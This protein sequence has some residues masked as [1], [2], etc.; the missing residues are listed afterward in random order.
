M[1]ANDTTFGQDAN[2]YRAA[3]PTYPDALFDWI[4][5]E[6]P[7]RSLVWDV[8]TGSGQAAVALAARFASVHAT[9]VD[10]RQV[11]AAAPHPRVRYAAAPAERSGLAD[12]SADAVTV[13]TALHWFD[14]A[15]FWA[16][17]RR[18]LRPGGVFCAWTY[19]RAEADAETEARLLAPILATIDPYW[20][21]GN[22]LSW[23][24]Y[25]PDEIA[26]PFA[27]LTPPPFAC[28][29]R[30]SPAE[31]AGFVRSWSAYRKAAADRH[32]ETLDRIERDAVIVLG[33]AP[34]PFRLPLFVR[35]GRA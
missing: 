10:A 6:A 12:G 21:A 14:L 15:A 35:A 33:D 5:G 13:A 7:G 30:W 34:R 29:P 19:H 4:A 1:M 9:D 22:R 24:G 11:A 28:V 8:G 17:V 32:A 16:E 2:A 23:R 25:P 3:R 18:V 20:S 31:V 26:F 27:P